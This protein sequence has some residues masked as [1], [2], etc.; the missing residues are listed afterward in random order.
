MQGY[1]NWSIRYKLLSILHPLGATLA[2]AETFAQVKGKGEIEAWLL[3]G[4][5]KTVEVA[6]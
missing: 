4:E 1:A 6:G 5:L 2:V 3:R